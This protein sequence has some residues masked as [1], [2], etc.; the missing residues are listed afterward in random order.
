MMMT[1][2]ET[3]VDSEKQRDYDIVKENLATEIS[4]IGENR[5]DGFLILVDIIDST[6]RKYEFRDSWHIH[7]KYIYECFDGL[8]G[9]GSCC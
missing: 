9:N 8:A 2:G 6:K 5:L 7:T 4:G 1:N 3:M